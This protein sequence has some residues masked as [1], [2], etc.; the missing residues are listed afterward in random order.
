MVGGLT[1]TSYKKLQYKGKYLPSSLK[2][3]KVLSISIAEYEQPKKSFKF[4]KTNFEKL[5]LH[6][7]DFR[8]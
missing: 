5:Y 6:N 3:S 1:A 4:L 8:V 7:Q 2:V